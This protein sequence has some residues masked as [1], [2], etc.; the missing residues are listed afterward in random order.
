MSESG[1][2]YHQSTAYGTTG[3]VVDGHSQGQR[4]LAVKLTNRLEGENQSAGI[5][6]VVSI[7]EGSMHNQRRRRSNPMFWADI[8]CAV[9]IY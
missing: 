1:M 5:S 6:N 2:H 7:K 4:Q 8:C 3:W 9:C